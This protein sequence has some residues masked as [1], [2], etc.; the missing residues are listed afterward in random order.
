MTARADRVV[1]HGAR[2]A[3]VA[4]ALLFSHGHFLRVVG[5]RWLGL[6]PTWGERLKLGTAAL[7]RAGLGA[8][9]ARGRAVEPAAPTLTGPTP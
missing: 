8:R 2:A 1:A 4:R 3:G 7:S 6:P 5:A 9:G